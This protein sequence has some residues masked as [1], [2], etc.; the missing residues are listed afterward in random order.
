MMPLIVMAILYLLNREYMME[1]FSER[2]NARIPCGFIALGVAAILVVS[3]YFT[4]NK[5]AEIEI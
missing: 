4:M 1:F 3:G 2:S 5:L